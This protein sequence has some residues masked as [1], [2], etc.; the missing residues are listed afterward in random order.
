[1]VFVQQLAGLILA[2]FSVL[3]MLWFLANTIRESLSRYWRHSRRPVPR[4][5][6]S[7]VRTFS[8]QIQS[9]SGRAPRNPDK[10][11]LRPLP[12]FGQSSRSLHSAS[13]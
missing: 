5:V 1:M 9:N 8:P 4:E 13:R 2:G 11:A 10:G 12:Q 6:F 3:F 7:P